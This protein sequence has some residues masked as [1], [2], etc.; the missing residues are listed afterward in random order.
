MDSVDYLCFCDLCGPDGEMVTR[1]TRDNHQRDQ[2]LLRYSE[3]FD[4]PSTSVAPAA[5]HTTSTTSNSSRDIYPADAT[6][7]DQLSRIGDD[8]ARR[9]ISFG[10]PTRLSFTRK[11]LPGLTYTFRT[12]QELDHSNSGPH[13]LNPRDKASLSVILH[14]NFLCESL[15]FL[16]SISAV[17]EQLERIRMALVSTFYAELEYLDFKKSIEW[18]NQLLEHDALIVRSG[19][20]IIYILK[21]PQPYMQLY[22]PLYAAIQS[23]FGSND[24]RLL[25]ICP[26][27]SMSIS[28][29]P[30][31]NKSCSGRVTVNST[32]GSS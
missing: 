23:V 9:K 30:T 15:M 19:E 20:F 8:L 14:E 3:S 18:K 31:A 4:A 21:T 16:K 17:A 1:P 32:A 27:C 5:S 11:P 22:R 7:E 6:V 25:H 24:L 10:F 26:C 12:T 2:K 13:P 29:F 28:R